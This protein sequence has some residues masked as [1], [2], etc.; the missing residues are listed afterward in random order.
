MDE[1]NI[2][3]LPKEKIGYGTSNREK[4][5]SPNDNS[6]S[7]GKNNNFEKV[8]VRNSFS[9]TKTKDTNKSSSTASSRRRKKYQLEYDESLSFSS[10]HTA[11]LISLWVIFMI[12]FIC[13]FVVH[14]DTEK[15]VTASSIL[16]TF[17]AIIFMVSLAYSYAYYK[18]AKAKSEE[19]L[20][21]YLKYI[22]C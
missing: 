21:K 6:S 7:N 11:Y 12:S 16:W 18:C 2:E 5:V 10:R 13:G 15:N 14:F 1:Q 17:S 19:E 20:Q 9:S 8:E 3:E 22:P 4:M